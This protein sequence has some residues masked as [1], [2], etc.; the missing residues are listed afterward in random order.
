MASLVPNI[1]LTRLID[2]TKPWATGSDL[3]AMLICTSTTADT[4]ADVA[5]DLADYT[6]L[7]ET[8]DTGKSDDPLTS[9][10][11]NTDHANDRAELD[12][13]DLQFA[14]LGGDGTRDFQGVMLFFYV[15][16]ADANDLPCAF[17]EFT[18]QPLAKEASQVDVPW[19]AEGIMQLT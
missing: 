6:T 11:V 18:N 7:D 3:R 10:T 1:G 16:G 17:I 4:N 2:G 15:D 5:N 12:A 9:E 8:D 19:D 14:S 13:D